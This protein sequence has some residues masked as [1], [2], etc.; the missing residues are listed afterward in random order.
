MRL[1]D[2]VESNTEAI[3]AEW[4]RFARGIAPGGTMDRLALRDHAADILRAAARDMRTPQ[5]GAEQSDKAQ[6]QGSNGAGSRRLDGASDLHAVGRVASGF[7]MM[8]MVSEY[9]ALRASVIRLWRDSEPDVDPDDL[10]DLTRFNESIDQSLT[11]AVQSYTRRVD[12]SRETFLAILGHDLRNPLNAVSMSAEFLSSSTDLDADQ[13]EAVGHISAATAVM[14]RM[15]ADL[16]DYTRTRLGAGMP[17]SPAAMDL[18]DLCRAVLAEFQAGHPQRVLRFHGGA[19]A[20]GEWDAARLRQAISNLLANAIQHGRA[21]APVDLT[22]STA[23]RDV[24]IAVHNS[25]LP[26]PPNA[27]PTIFEPLVRAVSPTAPKHRV[28][29]SIGL[30]LYIA[31]EV[32]NA[33]GGAID[34]T[35]TAADGTTF[36]VRLPRERSAAGA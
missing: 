32:V 4:E 7:D 1:A 26:I 15:I 24:V 20:T 2:F 33:H 10:S 8:E 13:S 18:T 29:G 6:G 34:V 36:T 11:T 30:G 22:L 19:A 23:G 5:T 14:G 3:L 28:T 31:R 25:G 12:Q 9:R 16:L 21:D 35:S 27:L 17:T